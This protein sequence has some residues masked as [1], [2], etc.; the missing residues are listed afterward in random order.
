[1]TNTAQ[2]TVTPEDIMTFLDGELPAAEAQVISV[3]IAECTE[4]AA[5]ADQFRE[6]SQLLAAFT[7]PAATESLDAAIKEQSSKTARRFSS[8]PD[9]SYPR[10]A[11]WK[12]W[13]LGGG[14]GLTAILV[15]LVTAY[16]ISRNVDKQ[17]GR[18]SYIVADQQSNV[19]PNFMAL[20]SI[21]QPTAATSATRQADM[22][23]ME[24]GSSIMPGPPPLASNPAQVTNNALSNS[25]SLTS[26]QTVQ[27]PMIART[28]SL[29]ILVNDIAASRSTLEAILSRRQGYA[30]QVN[31]NTPENYARSFQASLRIPAPELSAAIADLRTLGRVQTESQSGEEVTQQHADLV[32]RLKNARE[33]EQRLLAILQQ[34][35]GK[36]SEV[37]E[38]EEQISNTRGEIERMDAEQKA[39]EHRVD[40]ATVD[41]QLTEEFKAQLNPPSTS[42]GTRMRNAFITGIGNAGSSLLGI[43][44]FF[45]QYGPVLLLW[46]VLLGAPIA[47]LWRYLRGTQRGI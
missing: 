43:A 12:L 11:N 7:V 26:A 37:L 44:L 32:A 4:C 38:V 6:T 24:T 10:V 15:I 36:V 25:A 42:V 46:F 9:Y 28:V 29:T 34:R 41:L 19:A 33:T 1:M 14:G 22:A 40:F 20:Q 39:L 47:L 35:T 45:E 18:H 16:A 2:H 8:V 3:H 31:I 30:A 5:I 17:I 21:P 27:A 23:G 13:A